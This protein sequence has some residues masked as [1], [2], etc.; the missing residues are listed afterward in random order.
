MRYV[1]SVEYE[2]TNFC[3]WQRQSS[4][5]SIQGELKIRLSKITQDRY[6]NSGGWK[7]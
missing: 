1:A 6:K 4:V 3:G 2:G 5:N 7:N